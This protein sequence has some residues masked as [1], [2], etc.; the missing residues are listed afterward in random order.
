MNRKNL[1][2]LTSGTAVI[3]LT[4]MFVTGC[5]KKNVEPDPNPAPEGDA[6]ITAISADTG[7]KGDEFTVTGKN[8]STKLLDNVIVVGNKE[9]Q[10]YEIEDNGDGTSTLYSEIPSRF[11][12]GK[13]GVK[14]CGKLFISDFSFEYLKSATFSNIIGAVWGVSWGNTDPTEPK[15]DGPAG[16]CLT[17]DGDILLSE[18]WTHS[19]R[20]VNIKAGSISLYAGTYGEAGCQGGSL[21]SAKFDTPKGIIAI[22]DGNYIVFSDKQVQKISSDGQV[23]VLGKTRDEGDSKVYEGNLAEVNFCNTSGA[24]Y[25]AKN[26]YVYFGCA[27]VDEKTGHNRHYI[28]KLDL[29][30]EKVSVAAGNVTSD[31]ESKGTVDG[32]ALTV[33]RLDN[34][35][36]MCVASDGSLY[37]LQST[38][39]GKN[40]IRRLSANK[41]ST[42]AGQPGKWGYK[43]GKGNEA[44]FNFECEEGGHEP[45]GNIIE[46][47]DGNFLIADFG[48]HAIRKMT[49]DGT[50][51]TVNEVDIAEEGENLR[52]NKWAYKDD[53]DP[54]MGN[55]LGAS[56]FAA[57]PNYIFKIED[58][59]YGFLQYTGDAPGIRQISFE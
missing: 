15:F 27:D 21:L 58:Y 31:T 29:Q 37:F 6:V 30:T 35:A 10:P 53:Y 50:V 18:Q 4:A 51:T 13:V 54:T 42:V 33:A 5:S 7:K 8:F 26:G 20:K 55:K 3:L 28:L 45:S 44:I 38:G 19:I 49:P 23:I 14:V 9:L 36:R 52:P 25:D 39:D 40:C 34:P 22:N 59:T 57:H 17:P 48:N 32:D 43:N 24:A 11:G 46:D 56:K 2:I 47:E 12:S 41:V 16:A 1:S